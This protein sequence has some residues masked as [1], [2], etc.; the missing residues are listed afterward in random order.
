MSGLVSDQ[1]LD[2]L[3]CPKCKGPLD[4]VTESAHLVCKQC[5]LAYPIKNG[6]PVMLIEE[7]LSD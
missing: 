7:A 1:L 5:H 3:A 6:I 2:N 4:L